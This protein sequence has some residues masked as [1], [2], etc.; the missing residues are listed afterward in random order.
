MAAGDADAQVYADDGVEPPVRG[1]LHRPRGPAAGAL[2]LTHGA[3]SS[4][5]A[6]LLVAV[7]RAGSRAG[8]AVLRCDLPYR[9]GRPTGP[10]WAGAAPRDRDGLRRAV[11]AMRRLAP[12]RLVLGGVSYGGRQAS[13]LAADDPSVAEGLLLLS[14]PLHP[15]DRPGTLRTAH[16]ARLRTPAVFVHGT[17][18]P[19]G[20]LDELRAALAQ[21]PAPVRLVVIEGGAHGLATAATVDEV[22]RRVTEALLISSA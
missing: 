15:P 13:L 1:V 2:V 4:C 5:A 9:Q 21:V 11:E 8:L 10:P 18:D 6:P 20:T 14:Y 16:F 17:R 12:G 3:G 7:A 19:F 22:A